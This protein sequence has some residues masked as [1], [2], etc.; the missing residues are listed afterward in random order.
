MTRTE[1]NMVL[2]AVLETLDELPDGSS[3]AGILYAV[4]SARVDVPWS[5]FQDSLLACGLVTCDN[6]ILTIT[7]KGRRLAAMSR[8]FRAKVVRS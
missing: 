8:D 2:A 3:P 6:Y 7:D 4:V 1:M 5:A